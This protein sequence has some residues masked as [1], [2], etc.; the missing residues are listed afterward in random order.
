MIK[1]LNTPNVTCPS[2]TSDD[3]NKGQDIIYYIYD[4]D[5]MKYLYICSHC[6]LLENWQ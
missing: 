1:I 4:T 2:Y 6:N 3:S 5:N